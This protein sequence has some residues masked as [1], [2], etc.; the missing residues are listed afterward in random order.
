VATNESKYPQTVLNPLLRVVDSPRIRRT[1]TGFFGRCF[2]CALAGGGIGGRIGRCQEGRE[3]TIR[4]IVE[5]VIVVIV[6]YFAVRFFRMR[7]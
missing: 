5:I 2:A 4:T 1:V 3:M 7:G 6:I